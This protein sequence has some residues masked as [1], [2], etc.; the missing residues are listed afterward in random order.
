MLPYLF[1]KV[2]PCITAQSGSVS[3]EEANEAGTILERHFPHV[4]TALQKLWGHPELEIYFQRL[5][6]D[7]RGSR[8]GFPEEAWGEIYFLMALHQAAFPCAVR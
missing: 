4:V 3:W 8:K 6:M 2:E 1:E 5:T 7:D